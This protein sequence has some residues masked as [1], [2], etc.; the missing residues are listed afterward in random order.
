MNILDIIEK[1][2]HAV[3][4]TKD[5]INYFIAEYSKGTI[6]DYQMSALLM[7]IWFNGMN[8]QETSHL[9]MA[10]VA[11]GKTI[12]LSR[13]HGIKVDKHSS[14]GVADTVSLPLVALVAANG[15]PVAKM[16]GR[17]LGHTG[18]TID[19]LEAIPGF[20]V[21]I[22]EERFIEIVNSV[23]GA[24]ISQS[25]ELVLAD[26]KLYALR[27][28]T[29]TV[30]SIPLI[31]SSIMSKKI[32]SGSD[33]IVLDV[34]VGNGAFMENLHE[35]KKLAA[36]MVRIGTSVGR[37][38]VAYIT[39]MNQPLGD[40]IGNSL[41]V[42]EAIDVLK[43]VGSKRLVEVIKILGA[44]ILKLGQR[45]ST[46]EDGKALIAESIANQSGLNKFREIIEAQGG[47]SSVLD[48]R[49]KLPQASFRLPIVARAGGF[50]SW[51]DTK[52]IGRLATFLG[53]GR[54]TKADKIDLS[55]GLTVNKKI[56][57]SILQ[58][59]TIG[60]I[61]ANDK[62]KGEEALKQFESL[63]KVSSNAVRPLPLVYARV[64]KDGIEDL[65]SK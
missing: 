41:E 45:V 12:D 11:S 29:A 25:D 43:G 44:E 27:D 34:K 16:S 65:S 52:G 21:E 4:L 39:D 58:G 46:L 26:K 48:D 28:V 17:G 13:I 30:D 51:F 54:E 37:E 15:V 19:K 56:G 6:P 8:D 5:E 42:E 60:M 49:M 33:A 57:D 59:E 9:T 1:K 55:V 53:A 47:D 22:P 32:A 31:A 36:L 40:A 63:Y 61:Y 64:S 38:T 18:G 24:I 20:K 50:V 14:G 23:G 7:A 3:A 10:M 35:A 62:A 2:K